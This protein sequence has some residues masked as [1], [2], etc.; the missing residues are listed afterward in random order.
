MEKN[1]QFM[2]D[3]WGYV[4]HTV[5]LNNFTISYTWEG[6]FISREDAARAQALNDARY[7]TDLKKIKKMANIQFT[8]KEYIEYWLSEVFLKSTDTS[9][10]TIGVWSI[11]NLIIPNVNQD[12]LLNYV[13][14][15][16]INDIIERCIPISTSSGE[17]VLKFIR[18][19]LK[20]AY[21]YGLI[22]NDIRKDLMNVSRNVPKIQLLNTSELRQLI[23]EASRHPGCYFEILLGLFAGLRTGEIRG[24]RYE[25]FD[26]ER[27]TIRIS[28]QY[29][30]N[31]S[32]ADSNGHFRYVN[33]M[34]E[35]V[36][37]A[38][39]YRLLRVPD[40]LFEELERKREF[41][42]AIIRNR[43][44][45]GITDLD[46]EYVSISPFG[47]RKK[48]GTLLTSL[49]RMCYSASVP[50]ISFHTLRHQ[51]A[52]MLI[53]KGIPLEDISRLLGHKSVLTTFNIYCGVMDAKEEAK[54]AVDT[55]LPVGEVPV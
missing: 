37:K 29:T 36:P 15:D 44:A 41:N 52:T 54:K 11:R 32:L 51:F 8:F 22:P 53:E 28:K 12:V 3:S 26:P 25:D 43:M 39:S 24:L 13:T 16:Y 10:R 6:G 48:K 45:A 23:Q 46:T 49:K 9:T 27:H 42:E 5:N 33:Y 4:K 14:A 30:S 35:K 19:M 20:D 17:T 18:K 34:E 50:A 47:K 2:N 31:Y 1:L 40:F 38:D 21:A 55:M 7:E